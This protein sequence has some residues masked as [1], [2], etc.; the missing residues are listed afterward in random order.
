MNIRKVLEKVIEWQA[1]AG[2]LKPYLPPG[3]QVLSYWFTCLGEFKKDLPILHKL[4]NDALKVSQ[5][6][7]FFLFFCLVFKLSIQSMC[8]TSTFVYTGN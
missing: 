8:I 2:Q 3:D 7:F 5:T 4:A 1:A 6:I